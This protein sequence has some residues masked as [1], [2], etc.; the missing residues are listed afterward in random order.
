M[1]ILAID[2]SSS[3]CS[4]ALLEDERIIQELNINNTRTHSENLM[5]LVEKLLDTNSVKLQDINLLACDKGPG[6]FTGIRIGISSI[7]AMAE[8]HSIPICGVTSLEG[9]A[10]NEEITNGIIVPIIDARN[11]NVY[12]ATFDKDYNLVSKYLALNINDLITNLKN[13]DGN[14][15][16]FVGDGISVHKELLQ[17]SLNEFSLSFSTN[18]ILHASNIGIC[19]YTKFI[20]GDYDNADSILPLYINK[21]Q[22]ERMLDIQNANRN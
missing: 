20:N 12:T 11:D 18:N 4:V 6:S 13:I 8:V 10:Y 17:N 1:K 5:P 22:A 21:S 19:G 9:L 14:D 3:V 15:I 16:T 2:T 7:K